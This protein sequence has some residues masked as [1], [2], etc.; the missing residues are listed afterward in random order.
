MLAIARYLRHIKLFHQLYIYPVLISVIGWWVLDHRIH[1]YVWIGTVFLI[2]LL[3]EWPVL[4]YVMH[5]VFHAHRLSRYRFLHRFLQ[6]RHW[7]HHF[8]TRDLS[9]M[10]VPVWFSLLISAV[11][12]CLRV[13]IC[14]SW[15]GACIITLGIWTGYVWYEFVHYSAH[16]RQPTSR[17]MRYLKIYHLVHHRDQYDDIMFGVTTPLIDMIV[18]AFRALRS[19]EPV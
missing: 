3:I 18:D 8:A 6:A 17:F 19:K 2:G 5:R 10:F 12:I 14:W 9:Y 11:S 16:F 7:E 15:Q 1:S 13:I 4:E